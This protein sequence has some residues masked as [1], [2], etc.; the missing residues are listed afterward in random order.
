M[1]RLTI[2]YDPGSI[3]CLRAVMWMKLQPAL[4]RLSFERGDAANDLVAVGDGGEVWRGAK[5]WTMCLYALER[6]RAL[7][8]KRPRYARALIERLSTPDEFDLRPIGLFTATFAGLTALAAFGGD[9]SILA[10]MAFVCGASL[11]GLLYGAAHRAIERCEPPGFRKF[12]LCAAAA[13]ASMALATL[14]MLIG[15]A[16]L[17]RVA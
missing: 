3:A 16:L 4:V 7:S 14:I 8:L 13:A 10:G 9:L 15:L 1:K 11:A 2:R 6:H 17:P 5:A 12:A